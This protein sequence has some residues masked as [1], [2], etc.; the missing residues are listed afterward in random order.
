MAL[1]FYSFF[2]SSHWKLR[3]VHTRLEC[4]SSFGLAAKPYSHVAVVSADEWDGV[5]RLEKLLNAANLLHFR[6]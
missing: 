3:T 5:Q 6:F 2:F 1:Q 4:E